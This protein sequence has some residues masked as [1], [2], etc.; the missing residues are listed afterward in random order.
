MVTSQTLLKFTG[1]RIHFLA[2]NWNDEMNVRSEEVL[3]HV[4]GI[5]RR[6]KQEFEVRVSHTGLS[7]RRQPHAYFHSSSHPVLP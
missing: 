2:G 3:K 5:P 6:P 1:Q 4:S 7:R